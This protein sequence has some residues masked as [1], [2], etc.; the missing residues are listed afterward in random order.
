MEERKM[1]VRLGKVIGRLVGSVESEVLSE[2]VVVC[3][4]LPEGEGREA[5][6]SSLKE[7]VGKELPKTERDWQYRFIHHEDPPFPYG[8]GLDDPDIDYWVV[9]AFA[10]RPTRI[11]AREKLP[12]DEEGRPVDRWGLLGG[13]LLD[14]QLLYLGNFLSLWAEGD[15]VVRKVVGAIGK[16]LE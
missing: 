13:P 15:P 7:V 6:L 5:C 10:G 11:F 9:P 16:T 2:A 4:S 14:E 3:H 12:R 8:V 1:G